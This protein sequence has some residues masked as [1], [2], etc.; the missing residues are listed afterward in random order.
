M[1]T[2]HVIIDERTYEAIPLKIVKQ[3]LEHSKKPYGV[4]F[5]LV[6]TGTEITDENTLLGSLMIPLSD[7]LDLTRN[8]T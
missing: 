4:K 2:K 6:E 5:V 1:I 3:L 8:Q 7:A